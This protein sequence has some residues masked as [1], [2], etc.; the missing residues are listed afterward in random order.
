MSEDPD[1]IRTLD[2][3]RLTP[4]TTWLDSEPQSIATIPEDSLVPLTVAILMFVFFITMTFQLIWIALASLL[5][6]FLAGC[7][8]MWPRV[9]KEIL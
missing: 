9:S 1:G 8:W 7:Y 3:G 5:A 2:Y 6:M 4:T